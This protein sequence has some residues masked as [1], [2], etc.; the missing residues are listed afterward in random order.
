MRNVLIASTAAVVGNNS[1]HLPHRMRVESYHS[2]QRTDQSKL[3]A[4]HETSG[5]SYAIV[6]NC[7]RLF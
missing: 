7:R 2:L 5:G 4:I 6:A 1:P 3:A